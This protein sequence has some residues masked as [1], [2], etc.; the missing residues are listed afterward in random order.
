MKF[1]F[2]FIGSKEEWVETAVAEYEAK[3]K[4]FAPTEV[5]RLKPVRLERASHAE[6]TASE[7]QSILRALQRD[8]LVVLC[9]ERGEHVDSLKFSAQLVKLIERGRG[10]IVFVTGGAFGATE[11]LRQ[12]ADWTWSFSKLVFNHHVAQVVCLEQVYR[13]LS[14]WKNLPYHNA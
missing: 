14:I 2:V 6:K 8:D 5:I 4:R 7:T 9:D 12:R 13:G 11:E 3:I 1:A 10:R